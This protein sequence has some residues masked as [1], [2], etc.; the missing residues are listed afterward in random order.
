MDSYLGSAYAL[1]MFSQERE[2]NLHDMLTVPQIKLPLFNQGVDL[3]RALDEERRR[4]DQLD[5]ILQ[6]QGQFSN[7][8]STFCAPPA[9]RKP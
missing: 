6:Y 2:R 4:I 9:W 8:L 3:I 1:L 5:P 7:V